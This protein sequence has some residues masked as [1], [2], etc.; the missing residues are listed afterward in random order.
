MKILIWTQYFWP[1]NFH[2]NAVAYSLKAQG[3]E[4]TVLTG[5]PNYPEGKIFDGYKATGIHSEEYRGIE[6]IR[7]PLR[8]RGKNSGK[9]LA[10]NY[11]SFIVSGYLFAPY[12]LRG[13]NFD[14]IFVYA[15]S[16]LLQ[17]LPAIYM[18][19]IKHAKLIVW[20][21]DIWPDVLIATGFIKS[22]LILGI[23]ELSVRYI[24]R[25]SDSIL[26]QS[27][28]FRASVERRVSKKK[29][30]I[31]FPNTAEDTPPKLTK[32][33]KITQLVEEIS[34]YFSVV[35]SGNIG[36]AQSCETIVGAADLLKSFPGIKFYLVGNGSRSSFVSQC[37]VDCGLRNVTMTGSVAADDVDLLTEAAS[38]LL[39]TLKDRP[40][41][42]ATIPSKLQKYLS[43]GKPIIA[44]CKG[45]AASIVI[46]ANAGLTCAPDDASSLADAVLK[47]FQMKPEDRSRLGKN[48]RDYFETHYRLQSRV[49]ELVT[50]FEGVIA[51]DR[52]SQR[53]A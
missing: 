42:S 50:H 15:P 23:V 26:I 2:I 28:G 45:E 39:L 8:Q 4:V 34:T 38:V 52:S 21:Q 37:I 33:T 7:I 44:S 6:V 47:L 16:P 14:V 43:S 19:W 35:F 11:L 9:E 31:F 41:L 1:E 40:S 53:V 27:E 12:A 32:S 13:R 3:V 36:V 46:K 49:V 20:V 17:A 5:K 30:I 18:S 51:Q 48:G 10:L 22:P 25:L 29:R 24:Y